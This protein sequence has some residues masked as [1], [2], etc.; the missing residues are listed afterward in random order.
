MPY[1][2]FY[3]YII[4]S[5]T[6]GKWYYGFTSN[7]EQRLEAHNMGLNNST[8]NKGPWKFIF[9]RPFETK[10]EAMEFEAYLKMSRNKNFIKRQFLEFFII[11][12]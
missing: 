5:L 12:V 6:T 7:P 4:E 2:M 11:A 10:I 3:V 9:I 1:T 8:A